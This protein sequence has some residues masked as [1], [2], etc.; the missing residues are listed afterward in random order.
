VYQQHSLK[1]IGTREKHYLELLE[2]WQNGKQIIEDKY[3]KSTMDHNRLEELITA[4]QLLQF[5]LKDFAGYDFT[6][7]RY[8]R[9]ELSNVVRPETIQTGSSNPYPGMP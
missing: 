2:M 6:S 3:Y 1:D 8:Y 9:K 5:H 7:L 4:I